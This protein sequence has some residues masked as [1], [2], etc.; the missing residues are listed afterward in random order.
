MRT[1]GVGLGGSCTPVSRAH[2]A[3]HET[4][5]QKTR[6]N[7]NKNNRWAVGTGGKGEGASA[8]RLAGVQQ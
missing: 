1:T 2:I 4:N 5:K 8:S 7:K 3:M 6:K